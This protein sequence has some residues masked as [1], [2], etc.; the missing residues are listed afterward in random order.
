MNHHE[1]FLYSWTIMELEQEIV[2]MQESRIGILPYTNTNIRV[3]C[4]DFQTRIDGKKCL[5]FF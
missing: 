5:H 2:S 1:S 3:K 4:F